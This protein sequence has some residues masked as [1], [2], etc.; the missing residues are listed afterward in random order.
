MLLQNMVRA[1]LCDVEHYNKIKRYKKYNR[2]AVQV[3]LL[4]SAAQGISV[5]LAALLDKPSF[6]HAM[7]GLLTGVFASLI[8]WLVLFFVCYYAGT[9]FFRGKTT[10]EKLLRTLGY[11]FSP[12]V[13]RILAFIPIVGWALAVLVWLWSVVATVIALQEG[14][15]L[16]VTP[17]ILLALFGWLGYVLTTV[18]IASMAGL[19]PIVMN[20]PF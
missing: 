19:R 4:A 3:I 8:G 14:M 2:V 15:S 13:L 6:G 9:I 18:A 17:A 7:L 10:Y 20:M 12:R 16:Q 1:A 11:A 5:M